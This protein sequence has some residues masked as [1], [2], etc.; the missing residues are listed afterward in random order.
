[1]RVKIKMLKP[2]ATQPSYGR[3]GDAA[4]DLYSCEDYTLQPGE[5]HAFGLG[6]AWELPEGYVALVWDRGGMA[7]QHGIHSIAGVWDSNYRGETTVILLNTTQ[8]PY[9]IK[10]GDRIAQ[11]VIQQ[12]TTVE[13]EEVDELSD[14]ERGEGAWLS[15]GK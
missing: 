15:S 5:R 7:K 9:S 6:F 11:A 12:H 2:E 10:K 3:P 13:L 14:T 8:E 1:M 4:L